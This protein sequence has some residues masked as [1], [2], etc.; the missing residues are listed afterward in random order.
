MLLFID[1]FDHYATGDLTKKWQS[2]AS[3]SIGSTSG[4]RSG[5]AY[6]GSLFHYLSRALPGSY[7]TL[8]VGMAIKSSSTNGYALYCMNEGSTIHLCLCLNSASKL[9]LRRGGSSGTIL[10]TSTQAL[11]ST[12]FYYLELKATINDT[13]GSYELRING[14][15]EFS[16][17]GVDTRNGGTSGVIDTFML[18]NTAS[19]GTG[20]VATYDDLYICD[21][22]GSN[23]TNFLG[24]CRIDTLL[25]TSDGTYTQFT[26]STGTSHYA[27]VDESTP[28]TTDYNSDAT[29]GDRDSYGFPDLSSLVSQ[30]IFGVQINAAALKTDAGARNLGT[31]SRLSS[32]NKDGSGVALGTSQAYVSEIQ[33]TDPASAAWTESNVNAAEFGVKVTA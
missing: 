27:L 33:E 13:T 17:S 10:A 5:G 32:T 14:T 23:N 2:T 12:S 24:D 25:P 3:G 26:P 4:R 1:G 29:S 11:V 20:A 22:S 9:E 18:G 16:A 28:N 19:T 31:M 8:I 15:T 6:V 7:S 21:T 30:T